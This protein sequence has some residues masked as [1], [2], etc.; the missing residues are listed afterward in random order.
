[1]TFQFTIQITEKHIK[2]ASGKFFFR[3]LKKAFL[4][5][6]VLMALVLFM[7]LEAHAVTGFIEVLLGILGFSAIFLFFFYFA[8]LKQSLARFK[9][10]GGKVDYEFTDDFCKAK[11]GWASTEIKW[12]AFHALWIYPMVWILFS[13]DVGYCTLPGDQIS[14]EIREFLKQKI[15]SVGGKIK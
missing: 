9:K 14:S 6:S 15:I 12:G 7:Y 13:R 1:V 11:S 3:I 8:L 10:F 4:M 5:L 2:Y